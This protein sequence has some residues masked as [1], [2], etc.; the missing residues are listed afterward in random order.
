MDATR[1]PWAKT[2]AVPRLDLLKAHHVV[3]GLRRAPQRFRNSW[4]PP[5]ACVAPI[6]QQS[7]PKGT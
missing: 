6:S 5:D 2:H 1:P 7:I 3:A 4:S